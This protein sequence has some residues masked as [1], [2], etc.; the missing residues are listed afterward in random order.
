MLPNAELPFLIVQVNSP[1]EG[2]PNYLEQKAVIPIEGAIGTLENIE[3]IESIFT[4]IMVLS[5]FSFRKTP[6]L[7][8]HFLNFS[9]K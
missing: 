8:T 7:N 5:L 1:L 4:Q 6:I 9:K 2:D 3:R